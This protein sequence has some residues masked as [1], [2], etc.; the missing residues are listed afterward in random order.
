MQ[1]T[2]D[3]ESVGHKGG[4]L[5]QNPPFKVDFELYVNIQFKTQ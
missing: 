4:G 3:N 2:C 1:S 5:N